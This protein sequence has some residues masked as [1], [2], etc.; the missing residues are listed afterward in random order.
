M[1]RNPGLGAEPCR[2]KRASVPNRVRSRDPSLDAGRPTSCS[3]LPVPVRIYNRQESACGRGATR[4]VA[5]RATA[6]EPEPEETLDRGPARLTMPPS[7]SVRGAKAFPFHC[8]GFPEAGPDGAE[9]R[10]SSRDASRGRGARRR[11]ARRPPE[12]EPLKGNENLSSLSQAGTL[13]TGSFS[14]SRAAFPPRGARLARPG[15]EALWTPPARKRERHPGRGAA[16]TSGIR[17]SRWRPSRLRGRLVPAPPAER[18]PSE[19][20]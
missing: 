9:A 5:P 18:Q 7:R 14:A 10:L 4:A 6:S 20:A 13:E 15:P 16:R 19:K 2:K 1:S 3:R 12:G 8:L 17:A 11:A